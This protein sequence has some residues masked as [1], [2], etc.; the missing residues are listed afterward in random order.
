MSRQKTQHTK[1]FK[2]DAINYRKEHPNPTLLLQRCK[3]SI[4][5]FWRSFFLYPLLFKNVAI[6]AI[7]I[8]VLAN[9]S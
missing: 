9:L 8:V 7:S 1:Q 6:V 2:L 3:K 4:A 5:E